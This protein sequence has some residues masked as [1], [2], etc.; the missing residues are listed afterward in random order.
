MQSFRIA[1]LACGLAVL[2]AQTPVNIIYARCSS[3]CSSSQIDNRKHAAVPLWKV[4]VGAPTP[5]N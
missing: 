3:G 1:W 4:I 5:T 2:H